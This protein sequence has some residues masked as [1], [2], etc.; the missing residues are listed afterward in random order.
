MNANLRPNHRHDYSGAETPTARL[1]GFRVY[2]AEAGA[3]TAE[4]PPPPSARKYWTRKG[5]A[6]WLVAR[7]PR[8]S[9]LAIHPLTEKSGG[10]IG[11]IEPRTKT[12]FC[13]WFLVRH[14]HH[15]IRSQGNSRVHPIGR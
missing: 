9:D 12:A 2:L 11:A 15:P 5:I 6:E 10:L 7:S 3:I 8:L 1:N 13:P 14:F 4:V